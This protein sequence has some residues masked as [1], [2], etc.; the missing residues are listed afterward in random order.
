MLHLSLVL[1]PCFFLMNMSQAK[2]TI[3][4]S[5]S[6]VDEKG[7]DQ[8]GVVRVQVDPQYFRPTE[9]WASAAHLTAIIP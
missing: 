1:P 2:I 4:W 3:T 9:V 7:T 5:G 8:N 6:G